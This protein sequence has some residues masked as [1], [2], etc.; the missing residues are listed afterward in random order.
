MN[1]IATPSSRDAMFVS[2]SVQQPLTTKQR[3]LVHVYVFAVLI[4]FGPS[5]A[6]AAVVAVGCIAALIFYVGHR[7]AGQLV[8]Y[9]VV[10]AAYALV[11]VIYARMYPFFNLGSFCLFLV[12]ASSFL[13]LVY[14]FRG[15]VTP[16]VLLRLGHVTL[17]IVVAEAIVG[18]VQG[19]FGVLL[20][21]TFDGATGDFVRGTIELAPVPAGR[22]GNVMFAV[23]VS[24]LLLFVVGVRPS[25]RRPGRATMVGWFAWLQASVMHTVVYFAGALAVGGAVHAVRRQRR[26][27]GE[28]R[29]TRRARRRVAL[30]V[31]A[32]VLVIAV[33]LPRNLASLPDYARVTLLV[34]ETGVSEKAVALYNTLFRLPVDEP[35]QPWIGLGPGQY[36]SRAALIRSGQYL[37]GGIPF[38]AHAN[39]YTDEHILSLWEGFP[40]RHPGGGSTYFPFFSWMSLYGELGLL[41]VVLVLLLIAGTTRFIVRRR[42]RVFRHLPL[43]L[44]VL[45]AYL[46][47]LGV[48]DNYWEWTQAVFPA[49]LILRL[50]TQYLDNEN[51]AYRRWA[52]SWEARGGAP[53]DAMP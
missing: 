12:S 18:I 24:S 23:L 37:T 35:R 26:T 48:H 2:S 6:L 16:P 46:A 30:S 40:E 39:R 50:G 42:S 32:G 3:R 33:L 15:L 19:L 22:G 53:P 29:L 17:I 47:I 25:I 44:I 10:L 8:R 36:S 4:C 13:V 7:T 27:R 11:G 38:P 9:A 1:G 5:K 34:S 31:A 28:R 20:T 41:G 45:L 51:A 14:D 21:G 43:A 52:K 49:F